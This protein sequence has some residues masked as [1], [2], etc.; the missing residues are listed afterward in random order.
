MSDSS[1]LGALL[2]T[3]RGRIHPRD[4]GSPFG[5][6]SD[7]TPGLRREEVAWLAGVSADYVKRL[8]QGRSHP[9]RSVIRALARAL[10]LSDAEYTIACRLAGHATQLRTEVPQ[11]ITPSIQRLLS[12]LPDVPIAVFDAA[13][14]RIDQNAMWSAVTGDERQ[15]PHRATNIVWRSF[16]GDTGPVRHNNPDE[17]LRSLVADLRDVTIRYP[18]DKELAAMVRDLRSSSTEFDQIWAHPTVGNHGGETKT[19]DHPIIGPIQLDCD[20]LSIHGS[21]LRVIIFTAPPDS[22]ASQ[23]LQL[24]TVLG[25]ETLTERT[26]AATDSGSDLLGEATNAR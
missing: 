18:D 23:S 26:R 17:Y 20:V 2:R 11:H 14:T 13:W 16:V 8:E 21:D 7:K 3:W 6:S 25:T 10:R 12:R 5:R 24:L 22:P 15:R 1:E 19:I 9:S 4:V